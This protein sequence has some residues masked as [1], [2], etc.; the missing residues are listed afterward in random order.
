MERF[1]GNNR[2]WI[3]YEIPSQ[4]TGNRFF[5]PARLKIL[6]SAECIQCGE[7]VKACIYDVHYRKDGLWFPIG[8]QP[9]D[10]ALCRECLKCIRECPVGALSAVMHPDWKIANETVW[11]PI[12]IFRALQQATDGKIP[13]TGAGYGGLFAG[14]GFDGM[15]TDMSEI[16]R[17]TRDGIHSREYISTEVHIGRKLPCYEQSAEKFPVFPIPI[18]MVLDASDLPLEIPGLLESVLYA[19]KTADTLVFL[20]P[21]FL[22]DEPS[23]GIVP[24]LHYEEWNK[25]RRKW[26]EYAL[27][28]WRSFP[29]WTE[30]RIEFPKSPILLVGCTMDEGQMERIAEENRIGGILLKSNIEGKI[31]N[32]HLM[33]ALHKIHQKFLEKGIRDE[34]SI[35]AGGGI[36][37]A[38]HI[39]KTIIRGADFVLLDYIL[40]V[41]LQIWDGKQLRRESV[42]AEWGKWRILNLL[43][44]WR[45]QLLE[46]LGAMGMREVRRIRGEIGRAMLYEELEKEFHEM[47]KYPIPPKN[48]EQP[49]AEASLTLP[50]IFTRPAK[51]NFRLELGKYKVQV[52]R[53][54]IRCRLCTEI[55]P[56]NVFSLLEGVHAV[57]PPLSHRCTGVSCEVDFEGENEV[58]RHL[59]GFPCVSLC[60]VGAITINE[61]STYLVMGDK[62]WTPDLL[63]SAYLASEKEEIFPQHLKMDTGKSGG[64]FDRLVLVTPRTPAVQ[65]QGKI[66]LSI[67][68][69]RREKGENIWIPVPWYGGGMSFG[70]VS[71]NVM[72]ARAKAAKAF[73]TFVSTGEGG[74]PEALYPYDEHLITQIATGLFGVREDTIQRVRFVEFKYAQGAKPGLGGHLLADK[75][76]AD[77]AKMR[78]AVEWSSL[79]SPFPFHSVYSV[80]D[81]KKH[82]DW[83]RVVNPRAIIS[84]KVSTPSDVDMV[85]IGSY[86]AGANILH[87]DGGYGGTG[88]APE[89]AKKNIATPIEYAIPKVHRFLCEEGVRDEMVIMASGGIRTAWDIAK[90]VAMG[91]DGV[92]LGTAELVALECNKCGNCESGRGCPFGIATTDPELSRLIDPDW[93]ASRIIHLFS[94]LA[95][96][97]KG[98]LSSL[99][100]PSIR[101]LRGRTD[102]LRILKEEPAESF[103][104][105]SERLFASGGK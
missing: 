14:Y 10:R 105:D 93:G 17:P 20:P 94:A 89:V 28:V 32:E 22:P 68:L 35:G 33:Y 91:A 84:V 67:P 96:Q 99:G 61:D 63:L 25:D 11:T 12:H 60:P 92:V 8:E 3:R 43:K 24:V 52:S 23:E 85:A 36:S 70:S 101:Q 37:A 83:I 9:Q 90:A 29:S 104:L 45:N 51:E 18:P 40:L 97:L 21:E 98:I 49:P 100:L 42:D 72:L 74:Y 56:Q 65:K 102:L 78:E 81:H 39:P 44:A 34:F 73:R 87:I 55:C 76:T 66:D 5:H 26:E 41:A 86:Y 103:L 77:V 82:L 59:V 47:L 75:V 58:A 13:V 69:N 50:A 64:G 27:L 48:L 1:Y 30:E 4:Q 16:V 53:D 46:V 19:T 31:A 80:E 54:C 7:C 71:L 57:S 38:E 88:A 15:W 79:F 95:T 2:R 62:R 6:R